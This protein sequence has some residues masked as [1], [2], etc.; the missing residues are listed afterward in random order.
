MFSALSELKLKF[1]LSRL[2]PGEFRV[3]SEFTF[4]V[5]PKFEFILTKK[6]FF[7]PLNMLQKKK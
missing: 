2:F 1:G 4:S 3:F 5:V 7:I 6:A